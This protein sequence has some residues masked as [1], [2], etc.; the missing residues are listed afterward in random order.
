MLKDQHNER[1]Y[2]IALL[3]DFL[4]LFDSDLMGIV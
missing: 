3:S 1:Q 2:N 4:V